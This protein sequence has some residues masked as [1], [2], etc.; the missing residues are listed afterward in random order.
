MFKTKKEDILNAVFY[1]HY[2][3]L[4]EQLGD[5]KKLKKVA[6]EDYSK[7]QG[8][9]HDK[10]VDRVRTQFR[11]R[12]EMMESFKDNFRA[13]HRTLERGEEERD[14]G[15][16]CIYCKSTE[17]ARDSQ[18]HCL[19]CPA[20]SDLRTD[21]DLTFMEDLVTYFRR[22]LK[23]RTDREE[24]ERKKRRDERKEE[25]KRRKEGEGAKTNKRRRAQ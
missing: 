13:K 20:W 9:M 4:K 18:A 15:L 24:E 21:L 2:K 10:S 7:E 1:N 14:P 17:H 23:A 19:R 8:Y 3:D 16:Q 12:T 5:S 6:N 11:M 22:V 25:E